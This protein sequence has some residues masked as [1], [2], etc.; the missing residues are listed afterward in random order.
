MQRWGP[1]LDSQ[2]PYPAEPESSGGMQWWTGKRSSEKM[3]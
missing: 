2:L 1:W 3:G